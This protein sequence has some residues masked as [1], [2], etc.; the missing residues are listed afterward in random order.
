MNGKPSKRPRVDDLGARLVVC[1]TWDAS[2]LST[3]PTTALETQ[4]TRQ[5]VGNSFKIL[6][7]YV[8]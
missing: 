4:R 8:Y 5:N 1:S 7:Q 6:L 3:T 2:P